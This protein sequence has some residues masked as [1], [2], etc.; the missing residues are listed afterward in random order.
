MSFA[1]S[2]RAVLGE[3]VITPERIAFDTFVVDHFAGCEVVA[4][5]CRTIWSTNVHFITLSPWALAG[6]YA[7]HR[8]RRG[9][10]PCVT[11]TERKLRLLTSRNSTLAQANFVY[12]AELLS[13]FDRFA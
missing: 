5:T 2:V 8:G 10:R 3:T 9:R 6:N 1:T 4:A 11:D 12:A 7:M 13:G